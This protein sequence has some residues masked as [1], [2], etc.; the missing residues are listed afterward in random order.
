MQSLYA[1]Q[2][3]G[4]Q[5][6]VEDEGGLWETGSHAV[7]RRNLAE[8]DQCMAALG[9]ALKDTDASG[10]HLT[11]PIF[12][13]PEFERLEAKGQARHAD[14]VAKTV[15]LVTQLVASEHDPSAP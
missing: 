3:L 13:H 2:R 6:K 8:Y 11:S 1:V 9:G 12:D 14:R 5:V 15:R 7:L 4:I 10:T